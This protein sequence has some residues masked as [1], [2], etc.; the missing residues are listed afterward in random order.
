MTMSA[1]KNNKKLSMTMSAA[2][3]SNT[4]SRSIRRESIAR[5]RLGCEHTALP[6]IICERLDITL[7]MLTAQG[8]VPIRRNKP[9]RLAH[10][11]FLTH[12]LY[13]KK[14]LFQSKKP[15]SQAGLINSHVREFGNF[16]WKFPKKQKMS[17]QFSREIRKLPVETRPEN[18]KSRTSNVNEVACALR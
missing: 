5:E 10:G 1:V 8:I 4:C 11:H 14:P 12:M 9:R 6:P 16:L 7:E 13:P 17:H 3:C 15:H 2:N 18:Q